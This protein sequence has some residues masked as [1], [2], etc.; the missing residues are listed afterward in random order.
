[1]LSKSDFTLMSEPGLKDHHSSMFVIGGGVEA[2]QLF[3]IMENVFFGGQ[4]I[5]LCGQNNNLF[6]TLFAM[7]TL[8]V[9]YEPLNSN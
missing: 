8:S 3:W 4:V 9:H 7:L 6:E 5:N 2:A 1:M